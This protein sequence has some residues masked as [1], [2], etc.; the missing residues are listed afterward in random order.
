[1]R[2]PRTHR[3]PALRATFTGRGL[4]RAGALALLFALLG[5]SP[6][7]QSES[8][9]KAPTAS[10]EARAA[11][12]A[13][14]HPPPRLVILVSLDTVR[15]DH[16]SL[17]GYDRF[18]SPVLD[19]L[20]LEGTVFEDASAVAPWT[21]PSHASML[22]GL[23][24]LKHRVI[25]MADA[26]P[27]EIPTLASMLA[28]EG[29]QTAAVVNSTWLTQLKYRVTRDFE[30]YLFIEEMPERRAPN[31]WVTDQGMK[32][33]REAGGEPL[34]L[35]MHY[36]DV[37]SDYASEPAYEKLFV[38]PYDGEAD[39][40]SW[41]LT[42]SSLEDE[43]VE[44][45]Q[46]NFDP[47]VCRFGQLDAPNLVDE[48]LVRLEFDEEDVAHV[49][50]LYDAGIRQMDT[51][52]SRFFGLLRTEGFLDEALLIV[53]SDHG[54]EFME[55]GRLEHFLPTYQ[56]LLHVPL[57]FRG[58]GVP[59]GV[60]VA[61]PVSL[62]DLTPTVLRMVRAKGSY[63]L[64]GRDLAPLWW[65]AAS[66]SP[67]SLAERASEAFESRPLFAE[68]AGGVTYDMMLD[69]G[70]FPVYRSVRQGRYKLV[71]ESK[72]NLER[73]SL[74]DLERDPLE[75]VDVAAEHPDVATDLL[76]RLK[77]RHAE[78]ATGE[79]TGSENRVELDEQ[80]LERLRALGYVP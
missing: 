46:K 24:P 65:E 34:F 28:E 70:L 13:A 57:I 71:L 67:E 2:T 76:D 45:C 63:E 17:Y 25:T 68:A 64:D 29:F 31:T 62:I 69:A 55:H 48:N 61:S 53:T 77:R 44:K 12:T 54:E 18:T 80:E 51:E 59:K 9:T 14:V 74:Y 8:S 10:E 49:V 6:T 41:Q 33:L 7:G 27:D 19:T 37:H 5:C 32:W 39:G 1:M 11:P 38:G 20:A 16:L 35:F 22:T 73:H 15:A 50:D 79:E 72:P 58:P 75:Q 66:D 52:L 36:Y 43:Y 26:L 4:A 47:K 21:L 56:E 3:G 30:K 60:R 23:Y 42:A 40:T 78:G